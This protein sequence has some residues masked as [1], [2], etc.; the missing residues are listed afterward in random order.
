MHVSSL[1]SSSKESEGIILI[2]LLNLARYNVEAYSNLF[3]YS[4]ID[5]IFDVC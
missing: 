5:Q 1:Y 4:Y 2:I 3:S